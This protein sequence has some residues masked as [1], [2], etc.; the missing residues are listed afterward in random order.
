M[1][2]EEFLK[3]GSAD[4]AW[5]VLDHLSKDDLDNLGRASAVAYEIIT[6]YVIHNVFVFTYRY[7]QA[8]NA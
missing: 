4:V 3:S 7:N 2:F 6:S 5:Q 1:T 8:Q